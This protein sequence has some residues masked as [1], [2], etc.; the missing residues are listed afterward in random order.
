MFE[1]QNA[2]PEI[3]IESTN[4]PATTL[5]EW[6][7]GRVMPIAL[8]GLAAAGIAIYGIAYV[9]DAPVRANGPPAASKLMTADGF[10]IYGHA[11]LASGQPFRK[12][13]TYKAQIN[14]GACLLDVTTKAVLDDNGLP[15]DIT[16]YSFK[17]GKH[18]GTVQNYGELLAAPTKDNP[19]TLGPMPCVTLANDNG[20]ILFAGF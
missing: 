20:M 10:S 15:T 7:I 18:V 5:L 2:D 17:L 11:E 1:I 19:H 8:A 14:L 16:T 6:N 3:T 13:D 4:A 9:R 12:H